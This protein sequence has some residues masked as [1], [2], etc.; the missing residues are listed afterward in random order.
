MSQIYIFSTGEVDSK[1][2]FWLSSD[3]T[4]NSLGKAKRSEIR[5]TWPDVSTKTRKS[6]LPI[7]QSNSFI[8][9]T[10]SDIGKDAAQNTVPFLDSQEVS[11]E[12]AM[13]LQGVGLYFKGQSG[14]GGF[15]APKIETLDFGI[16]IRANIQNFKT[17]NDL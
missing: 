13:P 2:S 17:A 4:E 10:H 9:F 7:S 16:Y 8:K 5:L 14:Y 6:S 11:A 3:N 1:K 12:P 15:I